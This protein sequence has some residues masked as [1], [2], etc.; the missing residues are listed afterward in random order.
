[1]TVPTVRPYGGGWR[2]LVLVLVTAAILTVALT[3]PI[4]FRI[5]DVGRA[6]TADGQ[7]SLWNVAW[8]SRTLLT[9]PLHVFDANI[10][11]PHRGTLAYSESN[12]ATG[13]LGVPMYWATHN[14]YATLNFAVLLSVLFTAVGTYYLVRY[15]VQDRR[16]AAVSAICFAFCP[17]L[18]GHMA[19]VQALM[20]L[21]IPFSMLAFHRVADRPTFGRGAVLGLVMVT[22]A[23]FSGYYGVFIVLM[24]GFAVF[25]IAWTR[26][27]WSI[28][29]YW[30]SI[31][32]G[33]FVAIGIVAPFYVPYAR[34]ERL[35]FARTLAQAG[36]FAANWSS[37]LASSSYAHAWLL[38][39]LPRW[40]EVNFPGVIATVF[41]VAGFFVA[42]TK[43]E[44]EIVLV[45]GGLAILALWASFGPRAGLYTALYKTVPML[46]WL[47]TPSR[48]G[49]IVTFGLSVLAGLSVKRLLTTSWR[50]TLGGVAIAAIAVGELLVPL[51]LSDAIPIAPVYRVLATLPPGPVIEMPFYYPQVGLYQHTKYMLASTAHWMPLVNGYSDYTPPDFYAHV[52]TLAPF[53]SHDALKILEPNSVRYAVFHLYGY[54]TRNRNE[55]LQRLAEFRQYFRPIYSDET[56]Q[57]YEIVGYPK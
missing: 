50:G 41:G 39:F 23:L 20:T 45:Y 18:F 10:F 2:E 16:A 15:L 35:G 30:L 47:R 4:A 27:L 5:G 37:Y 3:Y 56:T 52:M 29:R 17:H 14:P 44:R 33:A 25:V 53:P 43:R 49:L 21:G 48:F 12:I 8:V 57:L 7:F 6:D 46:A 51:G 1:M 54:N 42:R 28:G 36:M 19:E 22:Q 13:L 38:Q 9:N 34:I 26:G 24:I 32:T 55:A 11:Y 31:A 40:T